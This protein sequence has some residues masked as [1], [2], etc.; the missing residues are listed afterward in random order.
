MATLRREIEALLRMNKH[1]RACI[2]EL[3]LTDPVEAFLFGGLDAMQQDFGSGTQMTRPPGSAI[4]VSYR[5]N[6]LERLQL[7][8]REWREQRKLPLGSD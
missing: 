2:Q 7:W 1:V 3:G 8:Q 5:G 4:D 6:R